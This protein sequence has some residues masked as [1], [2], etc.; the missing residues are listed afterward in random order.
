MKFVN[1]GGVFMLGRFEAVLYL[2]TVT[3]AKPEKW[4]V[5]QSQSRRCKLSRVLGFVFLA[6]TNTMPVQNSQLARELRLPRGRRCTLGH[7]PDA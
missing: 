7:I 2:S 6:E 5:S 1:D 4:V 3:M